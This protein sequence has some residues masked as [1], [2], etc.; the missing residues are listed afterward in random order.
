MK[1]FL[2]HF[3]IRMFCL[4]ILVLFANFNLLSQDLN[5]ASWSHLKGYW[6][7]QKSTNLTKATVGNNLVLVGTHQ[8][9]PGPAYGDTAVRIGIGSYYKCTHNIAANGG[10]DSVN[11]YTL[12]FDFKVLNLNRWHTFHQTDSTNLNDG[13]CFIKPITNRPAGAIGVGYT[14]YSSDTILAKKWYRLV[15][16]VNLGHFYNYYLNGTLIHQG[17]TDEIFIDKRFALTQKILFFAD[18]NQEDDT[19]DI[20]SVAIFDTCLS[21]T[22]IARIGSIDPCMAANRPVLNLG[23][24]T[25][26]CEYNSLNKSAGTNYKKYLWSTADTIASVSFNKTKLGIGKHSIWAKVTDV[27]GCSVTDTMSVTFLPAPIVNLGQNIALC[28]GQKT[29]LDAGNDT[30]CQYLWKFLP[31]GRTLSTLSNITSDS[32]GK[33]MVIVTSAF[34]CAGKDT[35]EITL[36]ANPPK[37]TVTVVG[38]TSFCN[39][40][41]V[42]LKAP[43]GYLQCRWQDGA[44][45]QTRIIKNPG[46]Y[47]FT[48]TDYMLC[49]SAYSDSVKITVYTNPTKP[50]ISIVGKTEFCEGDSLIL[51]APTGFSQYIWN[52]GPGTKKRSEKLSGSFY[53]SVIDINNC[54]SPISDSVVLKVNKNPAKPIIEIV[55]DST[56]C[57]GDS[58]ILSAASGFKEYLWST[59]NKTRSISIKTSQKVSLIIRD[60]NNCLSAVSN[61]LDLKMSPNPLKQIINFIGNS[62]VC[63]G[64]SVVLTAPAG[65]TDYLWSTSDITQTI[66]VKTAKKVSLI[67]TNSDGCK[68]PASDSVFAS[69]NSKLSKPTI[70]T[71]SDNLYC[72][73]TSGYY[74]WFVSHLPG[75]SKTIFPQTTRIVSSIW[76]NYYYYV[77]VTDSFGCVS[78][79]SLG[80]P[81]KIVGVKGNFEQN[82][83]IY[84]NPANSLAVIR[85]NNISGEGNITLTIIDVN[86][87]AMSETNT[88]VSEIRMGKTVNLESLPQGLYIVKVIASNR[89]FIGKIQKL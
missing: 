20:A 84:P 61:T 47:K 54:I 35:I 77:V 53:L 60:S 34:G 21:A 70:G 83:E 30:T 62:T 50:V 43:T 1:T 37:P 29:L 51:N 26:L 48:V 23:A 24:D 88:T 41:S 74:K 17:D 79:T 25:T 57:D 71:V 69:F 2:Q 7:F 63:E 89:I 40:D 28:P 13:E 52:D 9:V 6:K 64:D 66:S 39:G 42:L 59:S 78:D 75:Q 33:Y 31:S 68:S 32:F 72:S 73:A 15:V 49:T 18:N 86:G 82:P 67:V 19:I 65:F 16:S 8:V 81:Y 11:R 5:P 76:A 46:W 56:F 22:D 80:Y 27:N 38:Q 10:G 4:M 36:R 44:Y 87:K 14:G 58:I 12:M 85:I 55:G 3:L 45:N